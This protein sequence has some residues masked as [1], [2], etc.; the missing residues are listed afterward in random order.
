VD[1]VI[2]QMLKDYDCHSRDDYKSALKEITQ[3][4]ALLGLWRAKFF[5][6]GLFYGGTTLRILYKLNRFSENLDFSLLKPEPKF[7]LEPYLQAIRQELNAFGFEAEIESKVK[8][9]NSQID[10]AFIKA[11]TLVQFV[12]AKVPESISSQLQSNELL[13]IKVEV[14]KDPPQEFAVEVKDVLRPIPF[15]VKTMTRESLF[16]GKMHAVL[17]RKWQTRAKG[18]DY[19]DMI[20]Y[21]GRE[22]ACDL[23]HLRQRLTQSGNLE[24][25]QPLTSRD[26]ASMLEAKFKALD[27]DAIKKDVSPF[28]KPRDRASLE[29]WSKEF[30]LRLVPKIKVC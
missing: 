1:D 16:A 24:P 7:T 18:R 15:Q 26:L 11:G 30:F 14:D 2:L 29:M 8:N 3:E 17:A 6:K 19:F 27:I 13:K 28:L 21:I 22:V 23:N 10:S 12:N 4:I 20:W 5:E 9:A 25:E